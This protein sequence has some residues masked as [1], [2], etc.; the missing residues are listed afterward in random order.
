M[1]IN[2]RHS[3]F[4]RCQFELAHKIHVIKAMLM[5][6]MHLQHRRIFR[7]QIFNVILLLLLL[8]LLATCGTELSKNNQKLAWIVGRGTNIIIRNIPT[9]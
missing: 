9:T 7:Q 6:G 2:F 5:A 8:T 1:N 4:E 3:Q